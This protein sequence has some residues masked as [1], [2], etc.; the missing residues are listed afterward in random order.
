MSNLL[1]GVA[2]RVVFVEVRL[3]TAWAYDSRIAS[4]FADSRSLLTFF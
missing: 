4:V 1:L 3:V 2:I